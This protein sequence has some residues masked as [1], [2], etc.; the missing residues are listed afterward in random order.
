MNWYRLE[1]LKQSN[2]HLP[3]DFL[4]DDDYDSLNDRKNKDNVKP[5]EEYTWLFYRD[6][7]NVYRNLLPIDGLYPKRNHSEDIIYSLIRDTK[8]ENLIDDIARYER[9]QVPTLLHI[10]SKSVAEEDTLRYIYEKLVSSSIER[11]TA[12]TILS[13][14]LHLLNNPNTSKDVLDRM[15]KYLSLNFSD[16][17]KLE[18]LYIDCIEIILNNRLV[19]DSIQMLLNNYKG[20]NKFEMKDRAFFINNKSIRKTFKKLQAVL[21]KKTY[22]KR[23]DEVR[24]KLNQLPSS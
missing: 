10:I 11:H 7:M 13:A 14:I 2:R 18:D 8:D 9:T 23:L 16:F 12:H 15:V 4:T 5:T 6:K 19:V 17:N 3:G 24:H 21:Y 1:F 22:K 20:I